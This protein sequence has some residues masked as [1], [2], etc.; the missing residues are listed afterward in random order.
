MSA[1]YKIISDNFE[2]ATTN[3]IDFKMFL[4]SYPTIPENNFFSRLLITIELSCGSIKVG[5]VLDS[6]G[7]CR[8]LSRLFEIQCLT[9][10]IIVDV[11]K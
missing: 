5:H 1:V 6:S 9:D 10:T 2:M 3:L 8:L 11:A 4:F 7:H